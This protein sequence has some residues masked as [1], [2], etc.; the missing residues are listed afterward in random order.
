MKDLLTQHESTH[1]VV[2]LKARAK[3]EAAAAAGEDEGG[4]E[5]PQEVQ[6]KWNPRAMMSMVPTALLRK[7]T[8]SA[9]EAQQRAEAVIAGSGMTAASLADEIAPVAPAPA[10]ALAAAA[11]AAK[12]FK[13]AVDLVPDVDGSDDDDDDAAADRPGTAPLFS[14]GSSRLF[15]SRA[16]AG[17]AAAAPSSAPRPLAPAVDLAPDTDDAGGD[18]GGDNMDDEFKRF[19]AGL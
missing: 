10:P 9:L 3:P 14:C 19:M 18:G 1:G 13:A 5:K 17:A 6:M 11:P 4:E 2:E 7:R 12:R 15:S 16:H 8:A